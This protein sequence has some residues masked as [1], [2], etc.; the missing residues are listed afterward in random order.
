MTSIDAGPFRGF[1]GEL[2]QRRG[3]TKAEPAF[4]LGFRLF[5][6]LLLGV[7]LVGGVGGW[8][9]TAKLSGAVI[10][11][12]TIKVSDHVKEIQHRDGGIVSEIAVREGDHVEAGQILLR[13]DDV[14]IRA[15]L[16]IILGQIDEL[17]GRAARLTAERE[18]ANLIDF[19]AALI[20]DPAAHATIIAGETQL[21]TGNRLGRE[22]QK[23]QLAL[24]LEQLD[25]EIVG[26][27]AQSK[28]LR[29]EIA[30]VEEEQAKLGKLADKGLT[31]GSRVY[32]INRELTRLMG[33][34]GDVEAS[35]A[36]ALGRIGEVRLQILAIDETARNEAQRELRTVEASMT[37]LSERRLAA[38]DRLARSDI[39]SPITGTVNELHVT[40]IGGV[41]TP[42][43][44]LI[45][46]VPANADLKIE[47]K[48]RTVDVDQI[49]VGQPVK[50][51][52]SAFNQRTTPELDG[53][54]V[55]V[56]AAAQRDGTNGELFYVGEAEITGDV[57]ELGSV[58]LLPGMPVEV[59]V[60]TA[61]VTA[62]A[63]LVKPFMDQIA[64]AFREE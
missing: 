24:Q 8:A 7:L 53:R 4:G 5:L 55:H 46:I 41:I 27:K 51:R 54:I 58:A 52:F 28:A 31:E 63:Y 44:P 49:A 37:E 14:Q 57:H 50:L 48:L 60:Q 16:S 42:A 19:P 9:A 21:F 64:R 20:A 2:L 43:Q 15:E 25:Q 38:E 17:Q 59:F 62:I 13:L 40:T 11:P 56:S 12:G 6:S 35:T 34:F 29:E 1:R 18:G 22:R 61:E 45:T 26:L 10:A 23:E 3:R 36:R 30:L 47:V 33:E 32:A 39:R